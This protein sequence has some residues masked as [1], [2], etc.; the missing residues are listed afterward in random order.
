MGYVNDALASVFAFGSYPTFFGLEL[1][2]GVAM[3]ELVLI[4]GTTYL[5]CRSVLKRN[6]I[7]NA[8]DGREVDLA[9]DGAWVSQAYAEH[10]GA[11]VGDV[12][13]ID[14]GHGTK[15]EVPILGFYEFWL[16][17]Q[18]M[19]MGADYYQREFGDIAPN[20]VFAHVGDYAAAKEAVEG[21]EGFDGLS[22]TFIMSVASE[23]SYRMLE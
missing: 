13:V 1:F 11:K 22:Q 15:H 21:V 19:V 23:A 20:A 17:Y 7:E 9:G 18:E 14:T 2:F 5:A 8:V 10:A 12:I 4:L 16:L 3:A 6:A